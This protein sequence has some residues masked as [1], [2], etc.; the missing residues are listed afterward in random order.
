MWPKTRDND[1]IRVVKCAD[2]GLVR[3]ASFD[4]VAENHYEEGRMY[5]CLTPPL[6]RIRENTLEDDRRRAQHLRKRLRGQRL[7]DIGCGAGG[8]LGVVRGDALS[9]SGIEPD[10]SLISTLEKE[11]NVYANLEQLPAR[12]VFDVICLFHVLEHLEDPVSSLRTFSGFL[13][14]G[15]ILVIEVPNVED[16]LISKYNFESFKN[17]YFWSNHLHYF[18]HS[19]LE[20]VIDLAGLKLLE[21][22]PVQ[23]YGLLNH[24]KWAGLLS[25]IEEDKSASNFL[26]LASEGVAR[27]YEALLR[28]KQSFDTLFFVTGKEDLET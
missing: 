16:A 21:S 4:H 6:A 24:L 26:A 23:R 22:I 1:A 27:E 28:A 5:D 9:V 19:S 18:S 8:F 20:K 12:S 11:L 25:E 14:P 17:H 7:L 13:A 15:G 3:L 2:C 10:R